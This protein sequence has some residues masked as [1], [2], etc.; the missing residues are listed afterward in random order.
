MLAISEDKTLLPFAFI[1]EDENFPG[2]FVMSIAVNY[3]NS[4]KA[5]ELALWASKIRLTALMEP[6]YIAQ[7]GV[8]HSGENAY[9]YWDIDVQLPIDLVEPISEELH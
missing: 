8:T 9:K 4:E 5:V 2:L 3:T 1:V 6:F 7:N